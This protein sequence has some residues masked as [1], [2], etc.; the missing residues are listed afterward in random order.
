MASAKPV[1]VFGTGDYARVAAVYL[2]E[3]GEREVVAF[4]VDEAYVDRDELVGLP[5]VAAESLVERYP[6]ATHDLLVAIG[7]S[8]VN[9]A[10]AEVYERCKGA[11]YE[12]VSYVNSRAT[13]FGEVALG[14]NCFVF[15]E[16]VIQPNV[17]IGNDVV[18][19]SGNHIGHDSEI[20]DHC[21]VASHAVISGNVTIGPYCFVGVNATIRDG[22]TVAPRCVIGAGAI[23]MRDTEEGA[24]YSVRGTDPAPKKSWDLDL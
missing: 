10:R 18:L 15:E 24:V 4:T 17:R 16:N 23:I 11:G 22:V 14:D 7:F 12:L 8:R 19:W 1:V 20:G 5:V 13:R 9:Q 3:D 2:R 6:P 21:F